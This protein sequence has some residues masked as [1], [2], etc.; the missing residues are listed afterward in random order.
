MSDAKYL[1]LKRGATVDER[2]M[3][4]FHSLDE[5]VMYAVIQ[6]SEWERERFGVMVCRDEDG[7]RSYEF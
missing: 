3:A 1:V 2:V 7:R 4:E 5:A 6:Y